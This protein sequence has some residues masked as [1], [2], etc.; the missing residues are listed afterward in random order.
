MSGIKWYDN[1]DIIKLLK[2]MVHDDYFQYKASLIGCMIYKIYENLN[3]KGFIGKTTNNSRNSVIKY[4]ALENNMYNR[5][6]LINVGGIDVYKTSNEWRTFLLRSTD[7]FK[8]V[9][10][11]KTDVEKCKDNLR[12]FLTFFFKTMNEEIKKNKNFIKKMEKKGKKILKNSGIRDLNIF[13]H[14]WLRHNTFY[15]YGKKKK[16]E[17]YNKWLEI[18]DRIFTID[19]SKN[20][21]QQ[22]GW[23]NYYKGE[24]VNDIVNGIFTSDPGI[25]GFIKLGDAVFPAISNAWEGRGISPEKRLQLIKYLMEEKNGLTRILEL[26]IKTSD[27]SD[28]ESPDPSPGQDEDSPEGGAIYVAILKK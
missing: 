21:N 24:F 19:Y 1:V 8:I 13:G 6:Q 4:K 10:K 2:L 9:Q 28:P 25:I 12:N 18:R 15:K 23:V 16:K 20:S 3:Y 14:L 11:S 27:G 7:T 17:E 26:I 5:F 22:N